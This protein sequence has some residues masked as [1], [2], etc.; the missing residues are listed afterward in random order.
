MFVT[1]VAIK[2]NLKNRLTHKI[3]VKDLLYFLQ[4]MIFYLNCY[5]SDFISGTS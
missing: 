5:I 1:C 3:D 4:I 2:K